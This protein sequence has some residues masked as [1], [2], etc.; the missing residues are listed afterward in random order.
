ML[1]RLLPQR[2]QGQS[3]KR[4]IVIYFDVSIIMWS[5]GPNKHSE[6]VTLGSLAQKA[7]SSLSETNYLKYSNS[8]FKPSIFKRAH[9]K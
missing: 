4:L 7:S 8:K 2:A 3:I 6:D 1:K 9:E 5:F